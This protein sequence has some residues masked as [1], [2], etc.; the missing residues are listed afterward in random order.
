MTEGVQVPD[1]VVKLQS[2]H[3]NDT[4]EFL[5]LV[6]VFSYM[7][8]NLILTNMFNMTFF[9]LGIRKLAGWKI[10]GKK[11]FLIVFSFEKS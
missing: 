4:F 11:G 5:C 9:L 7:H 10:G 3:Q 2:M 8:L 1:D 6:L